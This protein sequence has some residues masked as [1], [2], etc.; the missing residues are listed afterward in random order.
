MNW[1]TPTPLFSKSPI[2]ALE[3]IYIYH[4]HTQSHSIHSHA[5]HILYNAIA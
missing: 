1:A 2:Q 3:D 5:K 4:R